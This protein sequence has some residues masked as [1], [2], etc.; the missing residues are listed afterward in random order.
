MTSPANNTNPLFFVTLDD[1]VDI[2]TEILAVTGVPTAADREQAANLKRVVFDAMTTAVENGLAKSS[3]ALWADS[4][5]GESVLLRAKAMSMTTASSPGSSA[6]SLEKLN[7]DYTGVQLTYNPDGPEVGR[8]ELLQRLKVVSDK[9]RLEHIPL[10][11]ELDCI[12]TTTQTEMYGSTSDARAMLLLTAIQQLQDAGVAPSIWAFEPAE[13]DVFTA[14]VVAQAHLDGSYNKVLLVVS[15]ELAAGQVGG[16]LKS[17]ETRV[18]R[19]AALTHGID[20]VL[21][22]PGAYYRHLVQFNEGIIERNEA[23]ATIASHFEEIS[24]IFEKSRTA[25]EVL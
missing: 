18:V 10:L 13:D 17:E 2:C 5:I 25:S 11:I 12:P 8:K 23:V 4:D 6:H 24:G 1:R 14:A 9:A 3:L 20:G 15:G 19:L 22:G 7:V 16:S 21:I